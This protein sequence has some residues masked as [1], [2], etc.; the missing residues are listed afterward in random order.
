MNIRNG[1]NKWALCAILLGVWAFSQTSCTQTETDKDGPEVLLLDRAGRVLAG[2][3]TGKDLEFVEESGTELFYTLECHDSSGIGE[4]YLYMEGG[5]F[6]LQDDSTPYTSHHRVWTGDD[7]QNTVRILFSV[8]AN[9]GVST[10][11]IEVTDTYGNKRALA[12]IRI[13]IR[14]SA[15][16]FCG[17]DSRSCVLDLSPNIR[18]EGIV[19]YPP[20]CWGECENDASADACFSTSKV[21][22]GNDPAAAYTIKRV[23]VRFADE[24]TERGLM[25]KHPSSESFT[26]LD[27]NW[28]ER[29]DGL[30]FGGEYKIIWQAGETAPPASIQIEFE[31]GP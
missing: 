24:I 1:S 29:W 16:A 30:T 12:P 11:R 2:V 7:A 6:L 22:P 25:V 13:N 21:V 20:D 15:S 10:L 9:A 28:S 27:E 26:L 18:C 19:G 31:F 14:A 3:E 8:R 4:V 23:R 5:R 17:P